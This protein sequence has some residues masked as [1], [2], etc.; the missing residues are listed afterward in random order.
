MLMKS[1]SKLSLGQSG[2][3]SSSSGSEVSPRVLKMR[4][5]FRRTKTPKF[6]AEGDLSSSQ[7]VASQLSEDGDS[8]DEFDP[9]SA[10]SEGTWK[11][12]PLSPQPPSKELIKLELESPELAPIREVIP[13]RNSPLLLVY[14]EVPKGLYRFK[15]ASLNVAIFFLLY[16]PLKLRQDEHERFMASFFCTYRSFTTPETLFRKLKELLAVPSLQESVFRLVRFW[17]LDA[18]T[19]WTSD[20]K[21]QLEQLIDQHK[22]SPSLSDSPSLTESSSSP[23]ESSSSPAESSSS[24]SASPLSSSSSCQAPLLSGSMAV[25]SRSDI[26]VAVRFLEKSYAKKCGEG[27]YKSMFSSDASVDLKHI[28]APLFHP[29]LQSAKAWAAVSFMEL[30]SLEIARQFTIT[31]SHF[32]AETQPV[33]FLDLAWSKESLKH[34]APNLTGMIQ[35]FNRISAICAALIIDTACFKDRIKMFIKWVDIAFHCHELQ[36]FDGAMA[37]ISALGGSPVFRLKFT[38]AGLPKESLQKWDLLKEIFNPTSSFAAYRQ[39]ILA[40]CPPC[41]PFVGVY[42]TDLTFIEDGNPNILASGHINFNKRVVVAGVISQILAF[43]QR[44]YQLKLVP[45]FHK[46]V[47]AIQGY[48]EEDAFTKSLQLEPRSVRS[49]KELK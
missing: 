16:R 43:K 25:S 20:M 8:E 5:F 35:N 26:H 44:A 10:L 29:R 39:A 1:F 30:D 23:A 27:T 41:I 19:D 42:L 9:A 18:F 14:P 47:G 7:T 13:H 12:L 21:K 40:S 4:S 48:S 33:E 3:A 31:S 34:L 49:K 11:E 22:P 38:R 24:P 15:G 36:N 28:P 45:G 2:E 32:F 37:V 17:F 6:L 46:F